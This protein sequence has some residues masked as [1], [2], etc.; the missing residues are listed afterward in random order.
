MRECNYNAI[1]INSI[2]RVFTTNPNAMT[3][4]FRTLLLLLTLTNAPY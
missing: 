2:F 3:L 1:D 4:E